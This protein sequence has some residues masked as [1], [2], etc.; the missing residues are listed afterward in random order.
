MIATKDRPASLQKLLVSI[1]KS[2]LLPDQ[3]VIVYAGIDVE[4][5][6]TKFDQILNIKVIR[7]AI[8]NQ[9]I[10]KSIGIK[11]IADAY[12]W[13]LF[14]DDDLILELKT[15]EYLMRNYAFNKNFEEYLG[16]GLNIANHKKIYYN[17][18]TKLMLLITSLY[19]FQPGSITRSGHP[20]SY[21]EQEN[22]TQVDWLNGT[23]LWRSEALIHYRLNGSSL[24]YSAYE[25]VNFSH[26][27]KKHGKL[28]FVK[29]GLVFHQLENI[30]SQLTYD[31]FLCASYLRYHFVTI[32]NFSKFWLLISQIVRS[33]DF[34]FQSRNF[35]GTLDR[36]QFVCKIW[37]MLFSLSKRKIHGYKIWDENLFTLN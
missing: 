17:F 29:K 14:L 1:S 37:L 28:L 3:V 7:S 35:L 2:T 11:Y 21:M 5:V 36:T 27:V 15:L 9:S 18:F 23:S 34:I 24:P 16:F 19:S 20:Q 12:K 33:L 4:H 26:E 10:Q 6:V 25:D 22:D 8:P 13:V 32:N 30:N 31:Q